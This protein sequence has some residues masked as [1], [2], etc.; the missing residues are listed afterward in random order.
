[1]KTPH[2]RLVLDPRPTYSIIASPPATLG[3]SFVVPVKDEADNVAALAAEITTAMSASPWSW[4]CVWVD[5][6]STD[7]TGLVLQ[8]IAHEDPRHRVLSLPQNVGQ[9][10]ALAAGLSSARGELFV[11]LDGDGQND[12][13][14]APAMILTLIR[15]RADM[16]NGC[17]VARRDDLLRRI[18]S[19]VGNGFRNWLTREDVRD[20]GCSL[21][22][23]RRDVVQGLFVFR[24][25]HRFLPTLARLNGAAKIV[26]VPVRHRPR[27]RGSTKYGLRNRL[28]VGLAD[29]FA[30]RWLLARSVSAGVPRLGPARN[31]HE[32]RA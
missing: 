17:R 15:A 16:V 4:E 10:A 21:R 12:P 13:R 32:D 14:Q 23:F 7:G 28:W 22:V 24:G 3:A 5:D 25:L 9:S 6:G 11:T 27:L 2:V 30:V 19:R 1:M 29:A 31:V 26:E 8:R 20:V 18:S